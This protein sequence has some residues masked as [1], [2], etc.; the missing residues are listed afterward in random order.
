MRDPEG[1]VS[2]FMIDMQR[3]TDLLS[4]TDEIDRSLGFAEDI[5]SFELSQKLERPWLTDV[6]YSILTI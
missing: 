1:L 3:K 4:G 6:D 5:R 2:H